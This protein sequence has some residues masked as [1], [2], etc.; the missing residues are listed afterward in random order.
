MWHKT[1]PKERS[2][3]WAITGTIIA[4]AFLL[5]T[6]SGVGADTPKQIPVI[7]IHAAR[8]AFTP[9]EITLKQGETVKLIFIAED[10]SHGIAIKGLGVDLELPKQKARTVVLTPATAGD[11]EGECSRYCGN[12]HSRMKFVVHVLP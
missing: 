7:T 2:R 12:G 10:I 1:R 3:Q 8:Y 11:F 5:L 4:L 9:S 6:R